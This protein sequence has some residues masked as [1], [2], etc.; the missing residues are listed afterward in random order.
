M[1]CKID[2]AIKYYNL[3]YIKK[4]SRNNLKDYY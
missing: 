2:A 3:K 1:A 4:E